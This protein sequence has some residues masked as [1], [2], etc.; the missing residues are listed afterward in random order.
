MMP[1][2]TM[3]TRSETCGCEFWSVGAP[4]VAQRVWPMATC[5]A[6]SGSAAIAASRLTIL[7]AFLRHSMRPSLGR[8]TPAE[9]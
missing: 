5:P 8:A 7:P 6:G 2:W 3:A 1:L 9:S 4:W